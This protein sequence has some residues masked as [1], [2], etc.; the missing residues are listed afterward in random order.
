MVDCN[1]FYCSCERLFDPSL[2]KKPVI[3]LS[4]NDGC[5]VART[6]EAKSLGIEM[7]TPG[8]MIRDKIATHGIAVFS[9]NYTLYQ[10]LSDR[11][12]QTLG[13]FV[14][15]MEVY[16]IDEAFLDMNDL[17][18]EDLL[19]LAITIR[20]TVMRNIGIPVCVGIAATKTLAKMANRY[21]KKYH[22][23]V[24]VFYAA[25]PQLV[26]ELLLETKVQDIWG[27]GKKHAEL[28]LTHG[29]VTA[30]DLAK[31]PDAWIRKNMSVVGLRLVHE[32]RGTPAIKWEFEQQ[33]KQHICTSR[34]FGELTEDIAVLSEAL[35][36]HATS[37]AT[38]LRQQQT[39]AAALQVFLQTNPHRTGDKQYARSVNIVLPVA[40]NDNA[41]IIKS[42]VHGLQ[43]IYQPGYR[44]KKCGVVV[45]EI[46]PET[47]VQA[48]LLDQGKQNKWN[49][50]MKTVDQINHA[51]GKETVRM[52]S[53]LGD[54]K[55]KLRAELLSRQYTT[56]IEQLPEI[57][58]S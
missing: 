10:D 9:S 36:N 25:N 16:S 39:A 17:P 21:A 53:Q 44:Y 34:S 40:A 38:K 47:S 55:W 12:M 7:G 4:N 54:K 20:K 28:L 11:V 15:G 48:S 2:A 29:I 14:P 43:L 58:E 32:L 26:N 57:N 1:A 13:S 46:V 23:D 5:A 41:S 31:T 6:D 8:F 37:C 19:G 22:Q 51:G 52:G 3:V 42:A 33:K 27:V 49:R 50:I 18:Y 56:N 35:A 24:G 45:M 30:A